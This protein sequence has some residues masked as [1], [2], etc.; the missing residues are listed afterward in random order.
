MIEDIWTGKT[1]YIKGFWN[2][3]PETWA[4]SIIKAFTK[5]TFFFLFI[6]KTATS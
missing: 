3:T 6:N 5:L 1:A 2:W 4:V